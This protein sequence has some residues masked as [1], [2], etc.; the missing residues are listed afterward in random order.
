M[1]TLIYAALVVLALIVIPACK[2]VG[3]NINLHGP[4]SISDTTWVESPAQSPQPRNVVIEEF[5]GVQCPNCP[6]GHIV[7]DQIVGSYTAGRIVPIALH[8][9]NALGNPYSY[10]VVN[11]E[12]SNSTY[13]MNYLI[14]PGFEP[15]GGV[16]RLVFQ[17]STTGI[18]T[19]RQDW[20]G[21]ASTEIALNPLVNLYD[22]V[23]FNSTTLQLK[24]FVTMHF[25]STI[26]DPTNI[27]IGLTEDSIKTAQLDG[28]IVD[29]FYVH[30]HVLRS[31]ITGVTGDNVVY[32]PAA[33][34]SITPGRVIRLVYQTTL[35]S[36]WNPQNMHVVTFVH[37]VSGTSLGI[38][39]GTIV[40]VV[41]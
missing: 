35:N 26:T 16:D 15:C 40:N 25:T 33:N 34:I 37:D 20:Q 24:I 41:N 10:S 4:S 22:S 39:Q 36:A 29:T 7:V 3:P 9:Y 27:T 19:T 31:I 12:D 17:G 28:T 23:S 11:L 14:F 1:K 30:N 6:A 21:F 38:Y 13:L 18:L 32:N 5:T 2:E 8:P